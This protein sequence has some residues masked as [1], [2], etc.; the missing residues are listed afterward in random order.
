LLRA[1]D[2]AIGDEDFGRALF[3]CG[4]YLFGDRGGDG[5]EAAGA[6]DAMLRE[7]VAVILA[8]CGR[9]KEAVDIWD[10]VAR[11]W[12]VVG[13]PARA[14]AAILQAKTLRP[15]VGA[16]LDH[17]SALYNIQ[18]PYLDMK[19]RPADVRIPRRGV[20]LDAIEAE[21]NELERDETGGIADEELSKMLDRAALAAGGADGAL[22]E[23]EALPP[24]PLLS[25]LP[26]DALRHVLGRVEFEVY[27]RGER[28]QEAGKDGE[29]LLWTV[30][31]DFCVESKGAASGR[32]RAE[33][34]SGEGEDPDSSAR[35]ARFRLPSGTLLGLNSFGTSPEPARCNVL[36]HRNG[37]L[38]RLRRTAIAELDRE[39]GDF[40]NRLTTLRR[41]ALSEGLLE[42]HAMF[43][44]FERPQRDGLMRRFTG[45]RA[46]TD[47]VLIEQEGL[48]PGIFL[49]LDG[50]VDVVRKAQGWEITIETLSAGDVF[51]AVG[52]VSD[53]L[54]LAS[55][56]M[57]S[58]GHLLFLSTEEFGRAAAALPGIAKYAVQLAN[59]RIQV[60]QAALSAQDLA[61]VD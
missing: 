31:S 34:G 22:K 61:E 11:Y 27:A 54:P 19:A 3:L 1:I 56:V 35:P 40:Y 12:A 16:L 4:K 30:T 32:E 50:Q 42:R 48:S 33:N 8:S 13:Q 53:S 26:A 46:A 7:R 9:K 6:F 25:L 5:A 52:V 41:H 10:Y 17:F 14:L 49:L 58:P 60:V 20:D 55:Y 51:G 45:I 23:P 43:T 18:S 47:E 57:T 21:M 28:V 36:S 59:K 24:L 39:L 37:E 44:Q 15:E 38:L 29:D 2:D